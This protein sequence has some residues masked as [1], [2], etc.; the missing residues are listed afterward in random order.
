MVPGIYA[1]LLV[2]VLEQQKVKPQQFLTPIIASISQLEKGKMKKPDHTALAS[3]ATR[4]RM[5]KLSGSLSPI[6]GY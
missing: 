4:T 6:C 5:P 3:T 1:K 2:N